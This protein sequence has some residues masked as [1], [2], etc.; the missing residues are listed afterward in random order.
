M[1]HVADFSDKA[2][3][4]F[5]KHVL[6]NIRVPCVASLNTLQFLTEH[7]ESDHKKIL[8]HNIESTIQGII[9]YLN[10]IN[11]CADAAMDKTPLMLQP[12]NVKSL[13]ND[14]L[15]TVMLA[16]KDKTVALACRY[17]TLLPEVLLGDAFRVKR[18]LL[19][20]LSYAIG[21]TS[22]GSVT[23]VVSLQEK[24]DR[25]VRVKFDVEDTGEGLSEEKQ[26][27]LF[28]TIQGL[29][30]LLY[31]VYENAGLG[32]PAAKKMLEEM[33]GE[34]HVRSQEGKGCKFTFLVTMKELVK[35]V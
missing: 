21:M 25:D 14:A 27:N 28:E 26:V 20:L 30:P 4:E 5:L 7:E 13:V 10:D 19:N 32:L 22:N 17:S 24:N 33:G 34:I 35:K 16:A 31:S 23:V 6:E 2:K 12:F 8:M 9:A 18:V 3:T 1:D 29:N 15:N 11:E